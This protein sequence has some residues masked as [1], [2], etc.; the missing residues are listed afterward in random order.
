MKTVPVLPELLD[1]VE[2]PE[3]PVLPVEPEPEVDDVLL[4]L[5]DV[6]EVDDALEV[7]ED[8]EEVP[9]L[10]LELAD[11]LE[12]AL[13]LLALEPE[14]LELSVEPEV[15]PEVIE[16]LGKTQTPRPSQKRP[17]AQVLVA[18]LGS[19]SRRSGSSTMNVQPP[20]AISSASERN[21]MFIN[22]YLAGRTHRPSRCSTAPPGSS[23]GALSSRPRAPPP[24][25][26][27][28][29]G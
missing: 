5:D 26:P 20:A 10:L 23:L 2:L 4:E 14:L 12:L 25:T 3:E 1:A 21:R 19:H 16:P 13:L 29:R 9:L 18:A 28:R 6:L 24:A 8:D 27:A 11:V 17:S 7:D 15:E 22:G